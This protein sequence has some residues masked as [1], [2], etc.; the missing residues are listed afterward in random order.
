LSTLADLQARLY[1]RDTMPSGSVDG[2]AAAPI[3]FLKSKM[4]VLNFKKWKNGYNE[5]YGRCQLK[6]EPLFLR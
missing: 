2:L 4:S 5:S 1:V 6:P 3:R